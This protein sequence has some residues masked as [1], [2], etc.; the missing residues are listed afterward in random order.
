M[1]AA[2]SAWI[3]LI[4]AALIGCGTQVAD[5]SLSPEPS[6]TNPAAASPS[7][8][9]APTSS[10]PA[11]SGEV[12]N[13]IIREFRGLAFA[14]DGTAYLFGFRDEAPSQLIAIDETGNV[15]A[16]WP[17]EFGGGTSGRVVIA[18]NPV[19]A[20]DASVTL[21]TFTFD[22]DS[23]IVSTLYRFGPDAGMVH[24]P[25]QFES[26]LECGQPL[27]DDEARAIVACRSERD[28]VVVAVDAAGNRAW[29]T[30][31]SIAFPFA[32]ALARGEGGTIYVAGQNSR[33]PGGG[34]D[35]VMA[36]AADGTPVAGWP[37]QRGDTTY[38]IVGLGRV[39]A[40][41]HEGALPDQICQSGGQTFYAWLGADGSPAEG[42]PYVVDGY[43]STP[44]IGADGSV[45][46]TDGGT[47]II[48]L[49][50]SGRP[51]PGWPAD[52]TGNTNWCF[53]PATPS[54][55]PGGTVFVGT[56]R[57]DAASGGLSAVAADGSEQPGWPFVPNGRLADGCPPI[58]DCAPG[59]A[60][61]FAPVVAGGLTFVAVYPTLGG[62][63]DILGLHGDGSVATGW[64][65]HVDA[66]E[67]TLHVAPDGRLFGIAT[68][69]DGPGEA[70]LVPLY[71]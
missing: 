33:F 20:A 6:V 29:S 11:A 31:T 65:V 35:G 15:K 19:V 1:L 40:W 56:P 2:R 47:E 70:Q 57:G 62:G 69:I 25:Y 44:A 27:L 49:D 30:P 14:P 45:Y 3:G 59:P 66:D 18:G 39:F 4:A 28:S 10:R 12:R 64:P 5:V 34:G 52:I 54:T 63:V 16:G 51:K 61:P 13:D 48:G 36:L 67:V 41:W 26:G 17:R 23:R 60:E 21:L 32:P 58:G 68:D 37:F 24:P 8:S 46:L 7:P 22:S 38:A 9:A 71:P 53:G 43:A 50:A 55:G 42:W